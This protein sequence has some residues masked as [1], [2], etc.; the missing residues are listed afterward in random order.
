MSVAMSEE[1]GAVKLLI[2][3]SSRYQLRISGASPTE[4]DSN[5]MFE[6]I[7]RG[8]E[9]KSLSSQQQ[10]RP[11]SGCD[12]LFPCEMAKRALC[13][14]FSAL[15]LLKTCEGETGVVSKLTWGPVH[16]GCGGISSG[17]QELLPA[18]LS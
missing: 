8:Q 3:D 2:K 14:F 18:R 15:L 6:E 1:L 13:W 4:A 11:P 12:E 5:H 10:G 16:R 9:E 7:T 17:L